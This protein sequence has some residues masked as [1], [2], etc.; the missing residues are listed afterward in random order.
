MLAPSQSP[1]EHPAVCLTAPG[2]GGSSGPASGLQ[3]AFGRFPATSDLLQ[4]HQPTETGGWAPPGAWLRPCHR[5]WRMSSVTA[6]RWSSCASRRQPVGPSAAGAFHWAC[7]AFVR[8]SRLAE[9]KFD[10]GR[11]KPAVPAR[12]GARRMRWSISVRG[13]SVPAARRPAGDVPAR[14]ARVT[15]RN[16]R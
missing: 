7:C 3:V 1:L 2:A 16:P 8:Q 5:F 15:A 4:T 14:E 11:P 12:S 13:G 9:T 6:P 10:G